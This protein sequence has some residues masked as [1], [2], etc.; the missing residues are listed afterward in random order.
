MKQ[1][2]EKCSKP[3]STLISNNSLYYIK[4][5]AWTLPDLLAENYCASIA[6]KH[7]ARIPKDTYLKNVKGHFNRAIGVELSH[8]ILRFHGH[9]V[10]T[11][12]KMLRLDPKLIV[13]ALLLAPRCLICRVAT[14]VTAPYLIKVWITLHTKKN[15]KSVTHVYWEADIAH[16]FLGSQNVANVDPNF[17]PWYKQVLSTARKGEKYNPPCLSQLRCAWSIAKPWWGTH[18]HNHRRTRIHS[19]LRGRSLI[20][21]HSETPR[22]QSQ[23]FKITKE[24]NQIK[25]TESIRKKTDSQIPVQ[26][27]PEQLPTTI[28]DP[29]TCLS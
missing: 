23:P 25:D 12:A 15:S 21:T 1:I 7:T 19:K 5:E 29:S 6:V 10:R 24:R 22:I 18:P 13:Y 16:I 11:D 26:K 17:D 4:S 9:L 3:K 20:V 14:W 27:S 28:Y 2:Q 8:K